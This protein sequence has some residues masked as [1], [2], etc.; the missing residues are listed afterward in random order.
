MKV[1]YEY[2]NPEMIMMEARK[3]EQD[4]GYYVDMLRGVMNIDNK[5]MSLKILDGILDDMSYHHTHQ[6]NNQKM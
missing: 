1:E 2:Q 4:F 5:I 3:E 6:K